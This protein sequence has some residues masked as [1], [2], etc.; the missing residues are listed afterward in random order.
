MQMN[1]MSTNQPAAITAAH[2]RLDAAASLIQPIELSSCRVYEP[3]SSGA[4]MQ[5]MAEVAICTQPLNQPS[6]GRVS[7]DSHE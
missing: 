5:K 2:Q 3:A 1:V 4:E 6:D 7:F